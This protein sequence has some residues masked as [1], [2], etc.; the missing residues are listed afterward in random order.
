MWLLLR[1][2]HKAYTIESLNAHGAEV[3][4]INFK[5]STVT[6]K[7]GR[8]QNED[9]LDFVV[10]E[11]GA[12]WAL[13][14]GLGGHGGG[15]VA[16]QLAVETVLA[17]FRAFPRC[18]PN[19]LQDYL[20]AAN[21]TVCARQGQETKLSRMR[22]TLVVLVSDCRSAC[23][24]HVGDSRLYY[25]KRGRIHVQTQDHSVPQALCNAGEI[26]PAQI[27]FHEDRNRLLRSIGDKQSFRPA[28]SSAASPLEAEDVFL[29]SSDGFW[30]YVNETEME[31]ALAKASGV[32][33]WL[34]RM[35]RTLKTRAKGNHD[36]Y[37]AIAISCQTERSS[38]QTSRV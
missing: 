12:C 26:T 17:A 1:S 36:N 38:R 22:S 27:R 31:E 13:A 6:E 4:E 23:W 14:D 7:G 9:Y 25:F 20:N 3:A 10:Q 18:S 21:V 32:D 30:E 5:T 8:Q 19:A 2:F 16:S 37:S 15:G 29:L 35:E 34:N 24:A 33:D 11:D 28:V